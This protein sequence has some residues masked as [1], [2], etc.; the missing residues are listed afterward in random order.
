MTAK[1][2][3]YL[4]FKFWGH[5]ILNNKSMECSSHPE[6]S[7]FLLASS[8]SSIFNYICLL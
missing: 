2:D 1:I 4:Y 5:L 6:F 7:V 3:Q 8:W